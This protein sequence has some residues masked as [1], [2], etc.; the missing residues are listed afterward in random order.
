MVKFVALYIMENLP[1]HEREPDLY[2]AHS[3]G[4]D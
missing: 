1:D 4:D 3:D 2:E